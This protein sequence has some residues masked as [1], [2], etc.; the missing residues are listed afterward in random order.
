MFTNRTFKLGTAAFAFAF[1]RPCTTHFEGSTKSWASESFLR[2][3]PKT[4]LHVHLDGS[5]RLESLIEMAHEQGLELPAQTVSGM[6][7]TVFKDSY[8]DLGEYLQG[9]RY[10]TG[11]MRSAASIERVAYEFAVDNYAEGVRYFEVRFAPQLHCGPDLDISS[12]L[13]AVNRG[14]ERAR[15]EFNR[16]QPA[17]SPQHEFGIIVCALR[18][19]ESFYS[20]H[21]AAM[22]QQHANETKARVLAI[23][24]EVLIESVVV[25]VKNE[26][27]AGRRLPVVALDLAGDEAG[28][29][30]TEAAN[31]TAAFDSAHRNMMMVTVHAGEADGPLSVEQAVSTLHA[32]RIGHGYHLFSAQQTNGPHPPGKQFVEALLQHVGRRRT[33]FEVCL[34]SN[35]QTMP[36]LAAA[37]LENHAAKR[38][39]TE[40]LDVTLNTDNRLVSNTNMVNELVLA[41]DVLQLSPRDLRRIIKCGFERSF[42][43]GTAAEKVRYVSQIMALY[44]T[45]AKQHGVQ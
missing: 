40:E 19:F 44:D 2:Q 1:N 12:C 24:A 10:T 17:S 34:T 5:L 4:D 18:M 20:P 28:G 31:Y 43:P 21:Y 11:V 45:V 25:A 22:C 37:G 3:I 42:F 35:L 41:V 15:D 7:K 39:L 14:L 9:F 13:I 16:K 38:M 32:D 23:A 30:G 29:E 6:R 33:A 26:Q 27:R 36:E 8:A